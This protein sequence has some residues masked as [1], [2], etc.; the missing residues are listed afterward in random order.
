VYRLEDSRAGGPAGTVDW[1]PE[2]NAFIG[3]GI[4]NARTEGYNR[5]VKQVKC[6]GCGFRNPTN[7]ARRIRFHCTRKQR[8]AT[9][10]AAHYPLK[11]EEP[12]FV[13]I[14]DMRSLTAV[15]R[16]NGPEPPA[17]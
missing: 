16:P 8:T 3:T 5:L 1:W 10:L 2:I 15:W 4:T 11:I 14:F 7:S 6:A 9:G 13:A 12:L 17:S